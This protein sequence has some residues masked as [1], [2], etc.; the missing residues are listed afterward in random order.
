MEGHLESWGGTPKLKA[1]IS[2]YHYTI[3][4]IQTVENKERDLKGKST[5]KCS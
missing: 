5:R 3:V 1:I 4:V 2:G